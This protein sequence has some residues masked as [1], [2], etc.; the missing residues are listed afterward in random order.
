MRDEHIVA[1]LASD[2]RARQEQQDELR[3]ESRCTDDWI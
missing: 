3:H 2:E 1:T